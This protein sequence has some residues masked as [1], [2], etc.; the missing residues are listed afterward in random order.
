M[1]AQRI[2]AHLPSITQDSPSDAYQTLIFFSCALFFLAGM[3]TLQNHLGGEGLQIPF[4]NIGWIII[5]LIISSALWLVSKT[6]QIHYTPL[7]TLLLTSSLLITLPIFYPN[8][9]LRSLTFLFGLWGGYIAYIAFLQF[10]FSVS[11]KRLFLWLI[12]I[13]VF[14]ESSLAIC[15][16]YLFSDNNSFGYDAKINRP[17]GI[18]FQPNLMASFMATGTAIGAY[19]LMFTIPKTARAFLYLN[20]IVTAFVITVLLSR[21]GWLSLACIT[22]L[23]IMGLWRY[24]K[25]VTFYV[26]LCIMVGTLWGCAENFLWRDITN[27]MADRVSMQSPRAYTYPQTLALW[28]E[29][30]WLG[31]GYGLFEPAYLQFS[32]KGYASGVFDH[33]GL[34]GLAHAHNEIL[35]LGAQGGIIPVIG[36]LLAVTAITWCC[37][38]QPTRWLVIATFIP[39]ALHTQL[40]YPFYHSIPHWFTFILLVFIFDN[41][42]RKSLSAPSALTLRLSA[43]LLSS[44]CSIF[45]LTT[46]HTTYNLYRYETENRKDLSLV[47]NNLNPVAWYRHLNFYLTAQ[48]INAA[49]A[50]EDKEKLKLIEPWIK[51]DMRYYPRPEYYNMLSI[52][53]HQLGRSVELA[54][55]SQ[56]ALYLLPQDTTLFASDYFKKNVPQLYALHM[57]I[58]REIEQSSMDSTTNKRHITEK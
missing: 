52:I 14:I 45:M 13:A 57:K 55:L 3:H 24:D 31:W 56:D 21:T 54:Q 39:L 33:P 17:Y 2:R 38:Q 26:T 44:L 23:I 46:M 36:F 49:V 30:P 29:K 7:T 20:I 6:R 19:L 18:F 41:G 22:P 10:K 9:N 47:V 28:L 5:S 42:K 53:Y 34:V 58:S 25:K 12:V 4:N 37:L 16:F 8:A 40:E 1:L 15:Q 48:S 51:E 43:I 11:Q 35:Q 50:T 32:A 27:L